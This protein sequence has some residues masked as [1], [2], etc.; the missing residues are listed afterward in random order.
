MGAMEN[1]TDVS[2]RRRTGSVKWFDQIKGFGFVVADLGGP[3]ILLHVNVLR[4]FGQNSIRDGAR[5]DVLVQETPRGLQ[6]TEVLGITVEASADE[7]AM[8]ELG[9]FSTEEIATLP[10][11]PAR[12]K[13]F[14]RVKGFGFANIFGHEQD[15]FLHVEVLRRSGFA[16]VTPGEAVALRLIEGR[17]GLMAV[18]VAPWEAA[19]VARA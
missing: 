10:L 9:D 15:V 16:D 13:W 2:Q 4:N 18:A 12:V 17:R 1:P 7:P 11:V 8:E 19:L 6:A 5:V 3:D 14:D